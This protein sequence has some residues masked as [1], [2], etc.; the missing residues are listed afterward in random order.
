MWDVVGVALD[1]LSEPE[2]LQEFTALRL[3]VQDHRGALH[4]AIGRLDREALLGVRGPAK[5]LLGPGSPAHHLDAVRDEESAVK[6][7]SELPD[8][9]WAVRGLVAL[10]SLQSL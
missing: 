1:Q 5:G 2:A 8:Q 6:T 10:S 7:D 4:V 3:H 9:L